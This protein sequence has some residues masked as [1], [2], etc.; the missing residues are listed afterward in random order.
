[1]LLLTLW[2]QYDGSVFLGLQVPSYR[3]LD[4]SAYVCACGID[5]INMSALMLSLKNAEMKAEAIICTTKRLQQN[6][7][8]IRM[9]QPQWWCIQDRSTKPQHYFYPLRNSGGRLRHRIMI[10][11]KLRVLSSP[12]ETPVYPKYLRNKGCYKPFQQLC[13]DLYTGLISY[14]NTTRTF[15]VRQIR[16]RVVPFKFIWVVISACTYIH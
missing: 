9:K 13:L 4:L 3:I 8:N 6:S 16:L 2:L 1:M 11:D 14:Y 7:K 15:R 5:L 10:S 12:E